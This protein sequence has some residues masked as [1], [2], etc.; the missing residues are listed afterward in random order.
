MATCEGSSF[1]CLQLS[2]LRPANS[3]VPAPSLRRRRNSKAYNE[4][5]NAVRSQVTRGN[6]HLT[7][8]L[9]E[10]QN[11]AGREQ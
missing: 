6:I 4:T 11:S 9:R 7:E 1:N 2:K 10:A 8:Q 3:P 5:V